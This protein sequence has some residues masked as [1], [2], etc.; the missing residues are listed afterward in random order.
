M[1][2]NDILVPVDAA[3]LLDRIIDLQLRTADAQ[4]ATQR[5][6]LVRKHELLLRLA[7]RI[8]PNDPEMTRLTNRLYA[9][10]RDL[11]ELTRDL[12]SCDL[13]K[14]YGTAFVALSQAM[15]AAIAEVDQARK[16]IA[17]RC[18]AAET[19]LPCTGPP[20]VSDD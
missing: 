16:A 17:L 20:D 5:S 18:A 10:R 6:E 14:D 4:H 8:L 12:Q 15:L 2:M 11:L 13:R 19:R 3:D 1:P 9:A 7:A